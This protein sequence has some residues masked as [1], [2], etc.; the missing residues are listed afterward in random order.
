MLDIFCVASLHLSELKCNSRA[1]NRCCTWLAWLM[2]CNNGTFYG[3]IQFLNSSQKSIKWKQY[4][5]HQYQHENLTRK[6]IIIR[7]VRTNQWMNEW[8][9]ERWLYLTAVRFLTQI[10]S[11]VF[12]R[13]STLLMLLIDC[14]WFNAKRFAVC[15]IRQFCVVCAVQIVCLCL[16]FIFKYQI[17][18]KA[19]TLPAFFN[20]K[21][22][23]TC[24]S[25][26]QNI[27]V[28]FALQTSQHLSWLL[29]TT[30][31]NYMH[32]R[33][34]PILLLLLL[35]KWDVHGGKILSVWCSHQI[36]KC[37][38]EREKLKCQ[39][40]KCAKVSLTRISAFN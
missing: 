8:M 4:D 22:H 13:K 36:G 29:K 14:T 32:F 23:M 40:K 2:W 28:S 37:E 7:R 10:W 30:T 27:V 5:Q 24:F 20:R 26:D 3:C 31:S 15:L 16:H 6:T 39:S 25:K 34:E 18:A 33:L 17:Q 1:H 35:R 38:C 12:T 21:M 11:I 9:N 19:D